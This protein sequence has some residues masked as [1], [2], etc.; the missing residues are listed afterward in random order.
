ME[1]MWAKKQ[2]QADLKIKELVLSIKVV[3]QQGRISQA[4]LHMEF[5]INR[6]INLQNNEIMQKSFEKLHWQKVCG[7]G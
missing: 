2:M 6:G 1:G 3:G 7:T 5:T 4:D